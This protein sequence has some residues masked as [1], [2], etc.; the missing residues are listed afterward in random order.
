MKNKTVKVTAVALSAAVLIGAGATAVWAQN[1]AEKAPADIKPVAQTAEKPD[2][3]S[4]DEIVYVLSGADGAVKKV[5]VSDWLQNT[6]QEASLGDLSHLEN[7][8]NVKGSETHTTGADGKVVWNAE[9]KDIYYQG[10]TKM[11]VPV[12]M[13]IRYTLDGKPIAPK[14]LAG[15]SGKVTVRFDFE[16]RASQMV[17]I[18]GKQQKIYV[19]FTMVTGVMLD[20]NIFHNVTVTNGK[21]ENIGNQMVVAGLAFPGLQESLNLSKKDLE[22]PDFVEFSADVKGFDMGST[23]TMASTVLFSN[24]DTEELTV[25]KLT[26]QV[27]Q[28]TDGMDQLMDGSNKLHKGLNTLLEQAGLLAAGVDQLT[29]GGD[30]LKDGVGAL[31]DGTDQLQA[32]AAQLS[33]GLHKLDANSA[34]LNGGA[35]QVFDTLLDTANK[36]LAQS[37]QKIPTLTVDNYAAVLDK[38][39]ASLDKNK[40]YQEALQQ[41]TQTVEGKR[42][43]IKNAVT[44]EIRKTVQ[45]E[46]LTQVTAGVRKTA[47]EGVQANKEQFRAA[48]IRQ[49]LHMSVADYDAAV[50]AGSIPKETQDAINAGVE[51]A[52][53]DKVESIMSSEETQRNIQVITQQ[54]TEETM[55]SEKIAALIEDNTNK[56]VQK[57]I[58]ETMASPAVQEKLQAASEGAKAIIGLKAS[59]DSYNS[60]YLGLRTYTAGVAQ[61]AAGAGDLLVGTNALK[62]GLDT[63]T[64]GVSE[65]AAGLHTMQGKTPALIDGVSALKDGS[66]ALKDGLTKLMDEGIQKIADLADKD[67]NTLVERI[68][69][70]THAGKQYNTFTG[71]EE[72]TKGTVKFVYKTEAITAAK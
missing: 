9:G 50:K 71:V 69:A 22:V 45:K 35:K 12:K 14:D 72:G 52:M 61:A 67:L 39:I 21:M 19:P 24:L 40:V 27:K 38:V 47:A 43:E 34:A 13:N 17:T 1:T 42:E 64:G 29:Q 54:K 33:D 11:E 31:S 36:Q 25:D 30:K 41:V 16:N 23:L 49:V 6:K 51:K 2:S 5:I 3:P 65:L 10:T 46:V 8:E 15:K 58:A 63:L 28:L 4:K 56:Q 26:D 37:G 53:A 32:G 66:K 60:F 59:L 20:T 18:N 7:I 48:V 70:V 68:K 57:I 44:A 55:K 62:G